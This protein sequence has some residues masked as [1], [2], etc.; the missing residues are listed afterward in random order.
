M[1]DDSRATWANRLNAIA[2]QDQFHDKPGQLYSFVVVDAVIKV[3]IIRTR[4]REG[5]AL[6]RA[7]KSRSNWGN[8]EDF[9]VAGRVS[10]TRRRVQCRKRFGAVSYRSASRD[11]VPAA[12]SVRRGGLIVARCVS[13][14]RVKT[15]ER[16][17]NEP[18]RSDGRGFVLSISNFPSLFPTLFLSEREHRPTDD[19]STM[20][21][22]KDPCVIPLA[23]GG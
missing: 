12:A 10:S 13:V 17:K 1:T 11:L 4:I 16:E 20:H 3:K 9:C 15:G 7:N 14:T 18:D 8:L 19:R 21:Q 23:R 5:A 22:A 2:E 6:R